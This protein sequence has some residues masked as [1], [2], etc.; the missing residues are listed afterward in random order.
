MICKHLIIPA[1]IL[2]Y[3]QFFE[4]RKMEKTSECAGFINPLW[5]KYERGEISQKELEKLL[6]EEHEQFRK[7]MDASSR[8]M[9]AVLAV[10]LLI[11]A[12]A[13]STVI[14]LGIR[15]YRIKAN[16]WTF[17]VEGRYDHVVYGGNETVSRSSH[18]ARHRRLEKMTAIYFD[19]GRT[20]AMTGF[21]GMEFPT[22]TRVRISKN[23]LDEYRIEKIE[24]PD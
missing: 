12:I 24:S 4:R 21:Y 18:G 8:R 13:I 1:V 23:G 3:N 6:D 5:E 20:V 14:Y 17:V 10:I 15:D 2:K 19:D 11:G 16:T 22:G 9:W 7:K